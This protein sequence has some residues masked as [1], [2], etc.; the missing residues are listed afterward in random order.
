MHIILFFFVVFQ[1]DQQ[2]FINDTSLHS[3]E[4][5]TQLSA[6][7]NRSEATNRILNTQLEALKRQIGNISQREMQARD[8]IKTLKTQLIRRPV[9]SVKAAERVPTNREEQL[10][11]RIHILENDL[12]VTKEE[13]RKQTN[14]AQCRR[15]KDAVDLGLWNKQK[16]FQQLSENLRIKLTERENELEKLKS[17]MSAAKATIS[18]LEREKTLLEGRLKSGNKYCQT[19]SCPNLHAPSKYTP[20]ESPDSYASHST[21]NLH[22]HHHHDSGSLMSKRLDISDSNQD[23]IDALKGRIESQQRKIVAMELEGRGSNALTTELERLQEKLSTIE[24]QNLRLEARNL[25]LQLDNDMLKQGDH[26]E[27]S[28]RQVKHLEE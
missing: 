7:L 20:A 19:P 22:H 3:A 11:K 12:S 16:R 27:K 23:I 10:Q 28:K 1:D 26:L 18:R 15:T 2:K 17:Y 4:Q 25:H 24:A 5:V 6:D 14:L 9:I 21:D 8:V 13:L